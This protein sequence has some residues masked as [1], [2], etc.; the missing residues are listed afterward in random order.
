LIF[1]RDLAVRVLTRVL[2][3]HEALDRALDQLGGEA[4]PAAR[5]WLQEVCAGTIRWKGRLDL[6]IDSTAMKKKPTGWLRK[7]LLVAAYQLIV[8]DRVAAAAV[9]SETVTQI[10]K[11]EGEPPAR[12]ANA[13]LRKIAEHAASWR[14]L[15]LSGRASAAEA[16]QWASL[17]EWI[18]SRIVREHGL[19]WA[20]A[21]ACASLERPA[22]WIRAR[23]EGFSP[24]WA[25][26]GPI[27]R[28]WKVLRQ[29]SG[30]VPSWPGFAEGKFYVQDIS[31]QSL[32]EGIAAEV[33]AVRGE[34]ARALDLCAA[35]GGKSVGLA[36]EGLVVSASDRDESRLGLLRQTV[37]RVAPG[38]RVLAADEVSRTT[39]QDL[40]WVDAPCSGSG[41]LRR[42]PDVRWLKR[43]QDLRPLT[44]LQRQ[45][46]EE[47]WEHV[48]PGGFLA[49]SVCSV[50]GEEGQAQIDGF[51][52][53]ERGARLVRSWFLLPQ[54]PPH[55]D[56]FFAA[57]IVKA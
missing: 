47:A 31:S 44:E 21:Y 9:V 30:A 48:V 41:I 57:V 24:E 11:R 17:P 52:G 25:E 28:S 22:I 29:P 20:K 1:P 37:E 6:A 42:H 23:E 10:R 12:F 55:G 50:L 40:V 15:E 26:E 16:A 18:W 7:A 33:R 2:S 45:L 53:R 19:D 43:E 5:G 36:W 3:D 32:V 51:L 13:T 49:Y 14:E 56:G 4:D 27:A 38:V 46:L 35:P 34:G 54:L 8:Q 39:A